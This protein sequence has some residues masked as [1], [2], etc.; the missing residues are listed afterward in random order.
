LKQEHKEIVE[1]LMKDEKEIKD[2]KRENV[3]FGDTAQEPPKL[4]VPKQKFKV[5]AIQYNKIILLILILAKESKSKR[6]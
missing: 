1:E 6:C 3:K 2:F 4:V 5:R